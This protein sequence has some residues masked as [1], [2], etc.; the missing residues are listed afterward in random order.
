M[1]NF[2]NVLSII[3]MLLFSIFLS[4]CVV[5]PEFVSIA[6]DSVQQGEQNVVVVITGINTQ[7]EEVAFV[8]ISFTGEGITI[9]NIAVHS[10]TEISFKI[11]I[12]EDAP[13]GMRTVTVSYPGGYIV[14]EDVFEVLGETDTQEI[15]ITLGNATCSPGSIS[16]PVEVILKNDVPVRGVQFTIRDKD[17]FLTLEEARTTERTEGFFVN[18]NEENGTVVLVSLSGN[19]ISPGTGPILEL[20]FYVS[21]DA[22]EEEECNLYLENVIVT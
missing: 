14:G 1:Y 5:G 18:F 16:G 22:P 20:L 2:K 6:P 3:L 19:N 12:A 17:G 10:Q 13:P 4:S 8:D 9:Y 21:E 11:D 7:F 15:T